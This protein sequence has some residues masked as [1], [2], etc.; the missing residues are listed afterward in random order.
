MKNN[1]ASA[2]ESSTYE[3]GIRLWKDWTEMWNGRP[4]LALTLV[5]PRF[6]L[7]LPKLSKLERPDPVAT[8]SI[9]SPAAVERLVR[10]AR[11]KYTRLTFMYECGPFVDVRAGI[12]AGPWIADTSLDGTP[13]PVCGRETFS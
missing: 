1:D 2:N 7:H 3:T 10:E 4:E 13:R 12:V 6:V 9:D 11:S 5:A 8:E